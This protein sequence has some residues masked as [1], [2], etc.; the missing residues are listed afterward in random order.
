MRAVSSRTHAPACALSL[1]SQ[2]FVKIANLAFPDRGSNELIS[3]CI[4]RCLWLSKILSSRILGGWPQGLQLSLVISLFKPVA[5]SQRLFYPVPPTV[6]N[7]V[8]IQLV[9]ARNATKKILKCTRHPHNQG[10]SSPR[11]SV[12][13]RFRN[14]AVNIFVLVNKTFQS[15]HCLEHYQFRQFFLKD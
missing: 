15:Y 3:T 6:G 12:V 4:C 2:L 5:L 1:A 7:A 9:E 10:L 11:A 14:S 13:P 8:S